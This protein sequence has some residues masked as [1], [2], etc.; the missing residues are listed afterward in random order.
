[1]TPRLEAT[2]FLMQYNGTM[3]GHS[4]L[5]PL[6]LNCLQKF[7]NQFN[8]PDYSLKVVAL[9]KIKFKINTGISNVPTLQLQD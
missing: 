4:F 2:H 7:R 1:M 6:L 9:W 8:A 3:I 5:S